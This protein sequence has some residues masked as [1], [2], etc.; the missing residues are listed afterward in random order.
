[1][2]NV[3]REPSLQSKNRVMRYDGHDNVVLKRKKSKW[4]RL[5]IISTGLP[6]LLP[7]IIQ[8]F[9]RSLNYFELIGNGEILLSLFGLTLP[10]AFD[11]FDAKE[12]KSD[13]HLETAF[14]RCVLVSFLLIIIYCSI[15]YTTPSA[16]FIPKNDSVLDADTT[17]LD[18][19][20]LLGRN[21]VCSVFLTIVSITCC[22]KSISALTNHVSK[23]TERKKGITK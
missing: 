7:L 6:Y 13:S 5:A 21:F 4:I 8:L 22:L 1:M 14:W 9:N 18:K 11:L 12:T 3:N 16:I 17:D 19:T 10:M 15:R 20:W 2:P 23:I